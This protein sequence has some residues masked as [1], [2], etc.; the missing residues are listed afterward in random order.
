MTNLLISEFKQ[1]VQDESLSRILQCGEMLTQELFWKKPGPTL[2]SVGNLVLHLQGNMTQYIISTLG[3]NP[4]QR[5]RSKEFLEASNPKSEVLESF[6]KCVVK[7]V[8]TVQGMSD[9]DLRRSYEVQCFEM[10]GVSILIHVVEHLSYHTGQITLL[11]KLFTEKE[12]GY[13]EGL[14]LE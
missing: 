7:C 2:N 6:K 13:Y 9:E 10:T 12:T 8:E 5:E 4:D 1:R 14:E 11:T 3:G